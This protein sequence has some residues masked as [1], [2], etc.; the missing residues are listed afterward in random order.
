MTKKHPNADIENKAIELAV[1]CIGKANNDSL[2][3]NLIDYLMGD[4]D[5]MPK[6]KITKKFFLN[7]RTFQILLLLFRTLNICSN[8]M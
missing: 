6:V 8:Y 1:E 7:L 5:G 4:K 3:N 2:T